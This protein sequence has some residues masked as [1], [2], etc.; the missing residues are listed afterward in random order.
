MRPDHFELETPDLGV[1]RWQAPLPPE[2]RRGASGRVAPRHSQ[3]FAALPPCHQDRL[4]H[5]D[6]TRCSS[7]GR[8]WPAPAADGARAAAL[9]QAV[10]AGGGVQR[11]WSLC[12]PG[13]WAGEAHTRTR[14]GEALGAQSGA[15]NAPHPGGGLPSASS[16]DGFTHRKEGPAACGR[17]EGRPQRLLTRH[18]RSLGTRQAGARGDGES[19][20]VALFPGSAARWIRGYCRLC[21]QEKHSELGGSTLSGLKTSTDQQLTLGWLHGHLP[22]SPGPHVTC[23]FVS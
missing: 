18:H 21:L 19:E 13:A 16:R 10:G 15:H 4:S 6:A 22:P 3:L 2:C 17:A 23:G 20:A 14:T 12:T 11:V 7:L 9:S 1:R 5:A 8:G